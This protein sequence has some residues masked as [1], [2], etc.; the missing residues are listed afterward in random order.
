M[1]SGRRYCVQRHIDNIHKGRANA[2]PFVEYLVG[3]R[4]GL[5]PPQGRPSYSSGKQRT[6]MEKTE[7]EVEKIFAQRTAESMLPA[8]GDLKY[9]PAMIEV[10][11]HINDRRHATDWGELFGILQFLKS[12]KSNVEATRVD[13]GKEPTRDEIL[14]S[15]DHNIE[16]YTEMLKPETDRMPNSK[17][18]TEDHAICPVCKNLKTSSQYWSHVRT[19]PGHENDALLPPRTSTSERGPKRQF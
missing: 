17:K 14:R 18:M 6:V 13:I 12:I 19:H 11:K 8:A 9:F 10:L 3:R 4:E 5:Y 2:I 16:Y 1:Y 7:D 15:S